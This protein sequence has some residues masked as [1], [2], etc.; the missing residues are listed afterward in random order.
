MDRNPQNHPW[1]SVWLVEV[2]QALT[3]ARK[4]ARVR[5]SSAKNW[6]N[7]SSAKLEK[8]SGV[9]GENDDF[10]HNDFSLAGD[11]EEPEEVTSLQFEC[12]GL[13]RRLDPGVS[14]LFSATS[15]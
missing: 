2:V 6:K 12:R 10:G 7:A 3:N 1:R 5:T 8:Q 15:T 9:P 13:D 4:S 14:P 11:Y